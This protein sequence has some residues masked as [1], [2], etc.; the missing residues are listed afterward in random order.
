[1]WFDLSKFG[2]LPSTA[3]TYIPTPLPIFCLNIMTFKQHVEVRTSS[4]T[5]LESC[6]S[7]EIIF[8][9][10]W[11]FLKVISVIFNCAFAYVNVFGSLFSPRLQHK[12]QVKIEIFQ[13]VKT[14][15]KYKSNI[16]EGKFIDYIET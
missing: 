7:V 12:I 11:I 15:S 13:T 14:I 10:I 8:I 6:F 4:R 16:M 1:M 9:W 2:E 5:S 3:T